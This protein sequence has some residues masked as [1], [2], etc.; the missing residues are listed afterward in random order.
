MSRYLVDGK[1]PGQFRARCSLRR[2]VPWDKMTEEL[3]AIA[4]ER[5]YT[6]EFLELASGRV[7]P[8]KRRKGRWEV[9]FAACEGFET[10]SRAEFARH[11]SELH[12]RKPSGPRQLKRGAGHWRMPSFKPLDTTGLKTC[13]ACGLVA[14]VDERPGNVL[15][16]AEHEGM[17]VGSA[18]AS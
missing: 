15:W 5:G 8:E 18:V 6:R 10:T 3:W 1:E 12:G 9:V 2:H 14:E 17:C 16:W 4:N 11:L 7:D 13:S